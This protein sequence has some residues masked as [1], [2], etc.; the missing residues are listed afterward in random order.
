M[1]EDLVGDDGLG[2]V[3]GVAGEAAQGE[4][5]RLLDGLHIV[6]QQGTE[7]GHHPGGLEGLDV[8]RACGEFCDSLHELYSGLLILHKW[9]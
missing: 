1:R 5:G 7:K 9:L 3:F 2:E 4:R 8:L 6:E